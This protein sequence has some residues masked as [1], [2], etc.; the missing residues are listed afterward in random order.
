LTAQTGNPAPKYFCHQKSVAMPNVQYY[1]DATGERTSVIVPYRDWV[2]MTERLEM[3]NQKL[4]ILTGL[5]EAFLEVKNARKN[6]KKLQSL[7]DFIHESRNQ[8]H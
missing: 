3:L 6:G 1:T 4:R 7:A 5:Q 8:H 2:E